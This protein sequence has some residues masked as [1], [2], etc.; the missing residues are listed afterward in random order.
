MPQPDWTPAVDVA[1]RNALSHCTGCGKPFTTAWFDVWHKNDGALTVA[2]A[3]CPACKRDDP[4]GAQITAKLNQR[5]G[6]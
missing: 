5:Y 3:A 1:L 4:S 6:A 2:V